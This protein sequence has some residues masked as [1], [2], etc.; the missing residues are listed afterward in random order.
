M[1]SNVVSVQDQ[2]YVPRI[3][4]K[5]RDLLWAVGVLFFL[6]NSDFTSYIL[7]HFSPWFDKEHMI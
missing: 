4:H 1:Y 6:P 3:M 5:I 7:G 2:Q